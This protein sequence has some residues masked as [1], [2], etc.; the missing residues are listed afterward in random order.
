MV[1]AARIITNHLKL[2]SASLET[3]VGLI[4]EIDHIVESMIDR[5]LSQP[6]DKVVS[7]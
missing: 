7:W 1:S 4:T 3:R 2:T 5:N 6:K